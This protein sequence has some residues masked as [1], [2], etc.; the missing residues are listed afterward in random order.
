MMYGPL[1]TAFARSS[2]FQRI[3]CRLLGC[4]GLVLH[5][6]IVSIRLLCYAFQGVVTSAFDVDKL[7]ANMASLTASKSPDRRPV[8]FVMELAGQN[9]LFI[10]SEVGVAMNQTIEDGQVVG[11]TQ[12]PARECSHRGI[13]STSSELLRRW[14]ESLTFPFLSEDGK[15]FIQAEKIDSIGDVTL[16]SND[17][18]IQWAV[19]V[20]QPAW[21]PPGQT[22]DH[23]TYFCKTCPGYSDSLGGSNP[24][25]DFCKQGFYLN[26]QNTCADPTPFPQLLWGISLPLHHS[27]VK[28]APKTQFASR[29][30]RPSRSVDSGAMRD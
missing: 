26:E 11:L 10:S 30:Q 3:L 24:Q 28:A 20:I 6:I 8:I 21:C 27:Q 7:E 15:W 22:I 18:F 1:Q 25:C 23:A 19:V 5:V 13:R 29:V 16:R 17:G 12:V 9:K 14:N 4:V 2:L